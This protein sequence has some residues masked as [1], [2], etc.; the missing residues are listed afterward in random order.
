MDA[1]R[2][3]LELKGEETKKGGH[4][5]PTLATATQEVVQLYRGRSVEAT[6]IVTE[7]STMISGYHALCTLVLGPHDSRNQGSGGNS[8]D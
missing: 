3:H 8:G 2:D 5:L 1:P 6:A 7:H 4:L